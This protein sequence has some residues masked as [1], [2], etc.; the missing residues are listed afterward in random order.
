[1]AGTL[2]VTHAL[3]WMPA[4]WVFD[5]VLENVALF[6]GSTNPSLASRLF[7]A[8]TTMGR[9]YLDLRNASAEE[10]A[11]VLGGVDSYLESAQEAGAGAFHDAAFFS[12]FVQQLQ[13]LRTMLETALE[14][15]SRIK[16]T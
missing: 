14:E 13:C 5:N 12:G 1:M 11:T 4:G 16:D 10:L 15:R 3:C 9:G 7:E 8:R 6:V 2:E